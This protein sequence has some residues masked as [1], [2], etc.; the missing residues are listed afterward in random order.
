[1]NE[2]CPKPCLDRAPARAGMRGLLGVQDRVFD[3]CHV[4]AQTAG[5]T[6]ALWPYGGAG[7]SSQK[8]GE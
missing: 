8:L 6:E 3:G 7:K 2:G 1:M 4:R 5:F